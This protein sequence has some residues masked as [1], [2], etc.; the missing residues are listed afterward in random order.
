MLA[1]VLLVSELEE[2]T[3]RVKNLTEIHTRNTLEAR[4]KDLI[5]V[6]LNIDSR[7]GK[8]FAFKQ[9]GSGQR[10]NNTRVCCMADAL[11]LVEKTF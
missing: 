7:D 10:V 6:L 3:R 11:S 5:L 4:R 8:P 9:S 1:S 2:I